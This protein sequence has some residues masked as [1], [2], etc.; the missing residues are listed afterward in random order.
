MSEVKIGT[1]RDT[2]EEYHSQPHVGS[3]SLKKMLISPG[4]F[5]EAWKGPKTASKTYDEGNITHSVVLD[6]DLDLYV[7]RPDGI[8]GRTKA[9]KEALAALELT[10]KTIIAANIFDSMVRRLETF[11]ASQEAQRLY[12][13]AE[14]ETSHYAKDP[15]TGLYIKARPDILRH[16]VIA[17]FK[18][19]QFMAGFE[20]Q[21][22][23]L[24]YFLQLGFYALVTELTTGVAIRELCFIAQEKAA[25]YGVKVF[26]LDK[27]TVDFSKQRARE[28]LN[29]VAVCIAENNFPI[30]DDVTQTISMPPW[31]EINEFSFD[32]VG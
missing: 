14:I 19:V 30:Y 2:N 20:K 13:H 7:R 31:L 1:Y 5:L 8:D 25:P 6:Q 11:S 16:G 10:G 26:R 3:S 18:T 29:R 27:T 23:N 22:W 9:G 12:D 4:H 21:I 17:D 28:T 24:G 32:E 15:E